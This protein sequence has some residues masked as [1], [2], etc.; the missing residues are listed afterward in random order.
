MPK[1]SILLEVFGGEMVTILLKAT[2]D[3]V[4]E[5]EETVSSGYMATEGIFLEADDEFIYLSTDLNVGVT[6][7]VNRKEIVR[8]ISTDQVQHS[9]ES[10]KIPSKDK[11]N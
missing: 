11:L 9:Q 1:S 5:D 4:D 3:V 7:A 2:Q 10:E 8:I 6:E